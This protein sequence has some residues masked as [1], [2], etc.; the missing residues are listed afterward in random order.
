M[1]NENGITLITLIIT[2]IVM[3]IIAG[4][5]LSSAVGDNGI[6]EQATTAVRN[7]ELGQSLERESIREA[8]D[9]IDRQ[10]GVYQETEI[11]YNLVTPS[12]YGASI[13]YSINGA[14]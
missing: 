14:Q 11:L 9:F 4:V 1:K 6:L 5:A 8:S 10:T 3:L 12:D 13:N 2:I 7:Q